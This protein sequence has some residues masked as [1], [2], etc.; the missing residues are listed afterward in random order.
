MIRIAERSKRSLRCVLT[1][2]AGTG[3]TH[4][5]LLMAAG[6]RSSESGKI[7]IIDTEN[8]AD[9]EQGK[10]GIPDFFVLPV[11]APFSPKFI[12]AAMK[13]A[14]NFGAEVVIIDTA[15]RCWEGEGGTLDQ[16]E[17]IGADWSAWAKVMPEMNR[18]LSAMTS[19]PLHLIITL[20]T[21]TAWEVREQ[22]RAGRV[23]M[24]PV[25][26]GLKPNQKEGFEYEFDLVF[27]LD[28][29]HQ[30]ESQK[31]RTS[32]FDGKEPSVITEETGTLIRDWL[33]SGSGIS[34]LER[35]QNSFSALEN[36]KAEIQA[37]ES[38]DSLI[39]FW[40]ARDAEMRAVLNPEHYQEFMTALTTAKIEFN[41][42]VNLAWVQAELPL[43][44]TIQILTAWERQN[45][46]KLSELGS[47]KDEAFSLIE[48]RKNE[49]AA[50]K[51]GKELLN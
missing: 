16:K 7:V 30:A 51:L 15:S 19:Y 4:S 13:E 14:M 2:P 21:K 49:L 44:P 33:N 11:S 29:D 32:L 34:P 25:K 36:V 17:K 9:L 24:Q 43:L 48:A 37:L 3:K 39:S 41:A 5:S 26:I 42:A 6:L 22:E 35:F 23:R 45:T 12:V 47:L 40:K 8:S 27:G 20:R 38:K 10:P 46:A 28:Q 18:M 31:D 1:G 50:E